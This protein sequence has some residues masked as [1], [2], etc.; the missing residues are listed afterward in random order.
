[1]TFTK[2]LLALL[3][4]A[5][6]AAPAL[7]QQTDKILSGYGYAISGDTLR[8]AA[9]DVRLI[10]V[11]APRLEQKGQDTIGRSYPAGLYARDVL[12]SLIAEKPISCRVIPQNGEE[13]DKNG[14]Y[15]G[16]C[17]T[18][19]SPDLSADMLTRGWA[20]ADRSGEFP[21]FSNY[22][23]AEK[24][25]RGKRVGIWQGPMTPPW[26]LAAS[27]QETPADPQPV[28]PN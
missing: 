2:S 27:A 12:A 15:F 10:G 20:F 25:G 28:T 26:E 5:S 23:N 7:A 8:I 19:S 21:I 16:A 6:A 17:A 18:S 4:A 3:I 13:K 9:D 14:R 24:I 11:A 22:A 1:M